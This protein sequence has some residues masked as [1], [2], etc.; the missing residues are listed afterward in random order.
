MLG[1][2][3]KYENVI[4]GPFF[5]EDMKSVEKVQRRATKMVNEVKEL[6]YEDRLRALQLPS[7]LHRRRRGDMTCTYKLITGKFKMNKDDFFKTSKLTTRGHN[8]KI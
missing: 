4:W 8:F 1:L 7:L 3:K 6:S 2:V 5:K